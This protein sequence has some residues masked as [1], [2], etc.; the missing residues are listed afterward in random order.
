MPEHIVIEHIGAAWHQ[1]LWLAATVLLGIWAWRRY[2][3]HPGGVRGRLLRSLRVISTILLLT[4]LA[5]PAWHSRQELQHPGSLVVA[6]DR[7]ASM[8]RSDRPD[9]SAR[10]RAAAELERALADSQLAERNRIRW[11]QLGAEAGPLQDLPS[12]RAEDAG[13]G[14]SA[15][16]SGLNQIAEREAPDAVLLVSDGRQTDGLDLPDAAKR[17]SKRGIAVYALP[18]GSLTVDPELQISD[19]LAPAMWPRGERQPVT[20]LWRHR[21][22]PEG[23][24]VSISIRDEDKTVLA[25]QQQTISSDERAAQEHERSTTLSVTLT[26]PGSHE[27]LLRVQQGDLQHER[28]L[29]VQVQDRRLRV[30]LLA[31]RPRWELR[32]LRAA[33][34][35][36]QTVELHSYLLA[37][38][39][40]R[41][42]DERFGPAVLR[43]DTAAAAEYDAII[44][45]DIPASSLSPAAETALDAAV[46][47]HGSGL[48]WLPGERGQLTS[49]RDRPL[50]RLLPATLPPA[51]AIADGYRGNQTLHVQVTDTARQLGLLASPDGDWTALPPLYGASP[52][53]EVREGAQVLLREAG[54]ERPLIITRA[55]GAGRSLL[56]AMDDTWRW[57]R[58][59]GDRYLHAMHSGLLRWSSGGR[60]QSEHPWRLSTSPR[61]PATGEELTLSLAPSGALDEGSI[62]PERVTVR[63]RREA[64]GSERLVALPRRGNSSLFSS[65]ISA[66]E[67]GSWQL[68]IASGLSSD[69]VG[70]ETVDI[71]TPDAERRDPRADPAALEN[72]TAA[73]GGA[74][75][76]SPDELLALLPDLQTSEIIEHQR[77]FWDGGLPMLLLLLS[78][79]LEW[80][81]RRR[82]RLP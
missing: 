20:I 3:P 63:L 12:W 60:L 79:C 41:W 54:N 52:V 15:L 25:E 46:R 19:V 65:S 70:E 30:L 33:L 37:G 39:W 28:R 45:G 75:A 71:V 35:R 40:Q 1:A 58:G 21:G 26:E 38:T 6:V 23:A 43:L 16:G 47:E 78:L 67:A 66:P 68:R 7:S 27:L 34:D 81:G 50:G 48:L 2:G 72:L 77:R 5:A 36:D 11:W 69:Q 57:R 22:L 10:I 53:A 73:T 64:D 13:A 18:V 51:A 29:R 56:I 74:V 4:L 44:L 32:Y 82:W 76:A 17:L 62:I 42:G 49:F 24:A 31:A 59:A 55:Y 8:A 9:G 61:R 80:A 14:R